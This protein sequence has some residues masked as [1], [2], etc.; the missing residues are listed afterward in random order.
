MS[1]TT[2]PIVMGPAGMIPAQ[3]NDVQTSL[4]AA[5]ASTN[6]GY[7]ANLPGTLI[8]DISS[9]DVAAIL[10]CNSALV[11]L[12]NSITPFGANQFLLNQLGQIYGVQQGQ[13]T[14]TS[15]YCVFT[16]TTGFTIN[17]GFLVSD[18]TYTYAV[19][20]SSIIGSSGYTTPLYCIATQSGSWAVPANSVTTLSTSV[21]VGITLTVTN[22][23]PGTASSGPQSVD[24]YR[25]QVLQGGLAASMGMPRYLRTL[26]GNVPGVEPNL[27]AIIPGSGTWEIIVGGTADPYLIAFAIYQAIFDISTLVG[28]LTI[29]RNQTIAVI[30]SPD[31]YDITFVVPVAQTVTISLVWNT[32]STNSV[33]ASTMAALGSVAIANYVNAIQVG[34]PMNLFELQN[35]FQIATATVLPTQLL[36]RMIFTVEINSIVVNPTAGTGIISGDPEGYFQTA[37]NLITITQG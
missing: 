12:L 27:V 1:G 22:P 5:V 36:T 11:E 30:D 23:N 19:Q 29:S 32:T 25:Q 37:T 4:L 20:N 26:L 2:I 13:S 8:E 3:P 6:P 33:S 14:N 31:T 24:Q 9:T 18:G 34:S 17:P 7:T 35:A 28:S 16:G 15:V 10:A 21:P